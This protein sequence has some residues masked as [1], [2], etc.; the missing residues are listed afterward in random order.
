MNIER[1][2]RLPRS[3][4]HRTPPGLTIYPSEGGPII[5]RRAHRPSPSTQAGCLH[6]DL[7]DSTV[8]WYWIME[9]S[10][11][12]VSFFHQSQLSLSIQYPLPPTLYYYTLL[13]SIRFPVFPSQYPVSR[14][15]YPLSSILWPCCLFVSLGDTR[16]QCLGTWA[17]RLGPKNRTAGVATRT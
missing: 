2:P 10:L 3:A 15:Q 6:P 4:G 11:R 16:Q 8:V 12:P 7:T 9:L 14:I 17:L 1:T 13:C 5:P